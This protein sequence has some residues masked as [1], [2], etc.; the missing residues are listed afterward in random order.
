MLPREGWS[1][2]FS[3]TDLLEEYL[4]GDRPTPIGAMQASM[5]LTVEKHWEKTQK[6]LTARLHGLRV[7]TWLLGAA[8]AAWCCA[9][10]GG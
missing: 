1:M 3:A 8:L 9:L 6:E 7:A 4:D 5:A 2:T 10:I